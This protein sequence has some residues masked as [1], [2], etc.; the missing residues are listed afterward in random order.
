LHFFHDIQTAV[1]DELIHVPRLLWESCDAISALFSSPELIL[2][3][4]IILGANYGK[5]IGHSRSVL[6]FRVWSVGNELRG[7]LT[8]A[9]V[10]WP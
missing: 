2:E 5:V 9:I 6:K 4:R 7:R 3:E 10:D 1:H 8:E